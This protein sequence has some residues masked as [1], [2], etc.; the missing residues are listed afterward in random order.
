MSCW[1]YV[2]AVSKYII[3][4]GI[5]IYELQQH[6]IPTILIMHLQTAKIVYSDILCMRSKLSENIL[7]FAH[8]HVQFSVFTWKLLNKRTFSPV[9][10]VI[11]HSHSQNEKYIY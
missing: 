5:T 3:I 2:N 11:V 9:A 4:T 6:L 1:A 10:Y 7:L 8:T